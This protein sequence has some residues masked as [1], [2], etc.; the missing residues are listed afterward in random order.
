MG[1]DGFSL[2]TRQTPREVHCNR[3]STVQSLLD[4]HSASAVSTSRL[5]RYGKSTT[6]APDNRKRHWD[7]PTP[8]NKLKINASH[9]AANKID[10]RIG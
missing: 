1:Q 2:K 8:M 5:S 6:G 4:A 9:N 3:R 10:H 7:M